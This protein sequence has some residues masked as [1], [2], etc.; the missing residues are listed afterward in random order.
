MPAKFC[1]SICADGLIKQYGL[2]CGLEGV[3]PVFPRRTVV[4]PFKYSGKVARAVKT[5]GN[6]NFGNT[7]LRLA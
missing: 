5:A 6:R 2:F 3:F 1:G 7:A 4:K